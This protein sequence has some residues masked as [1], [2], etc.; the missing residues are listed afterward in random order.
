MINSNFEKLRLRRLSLKLRFLN[1]YQLCIFTFLSFIALSASSQSEVIEV[2]IE[3]LVNVT[4]LEAR[5]V[6]QSKV[7]DPFSPALAARIQDDIRALWSLDVFESIVVEDEKTPGGV[8]LIYNVI[9]KAKVIDIQYTGN[10]KYKQKR[11]NEELGFTKFSRLFIDT[12]LADNYQ[13]KLQTFYTS[14]SFPNTTISWETKETDNENEVILVYHIEEGEKL[15]VKKIVFDGNSVLTDKMLKDRINTKESFWFIFKK[16]YDE[17]IAKE[18]LDIIRFTY[19]TVG[20]LD[21][22]A[23]LEPIEPIKGGLQVRFIIEEGE[24]Y[25]VGSIAIVGNSIYSEDEIRSM[26]R[27]KPG[28]LFSAETALLDRVDIQ[29]LYRGQGFLDTVAPYEPIIDK[30][31]KVV[32][33]LY[34]IQESDR[35]FLGKVDIVGGAVLDDGTFVPAQEGE[36]AT[37]DFVILREIELE[38]GEPLDWTR[39]LESDRNLINLDYFESR[40]FPVPGQLNLYP[41]FIRRKTS[42]PNIENLELRLQEKET[43]VLSFGAGLSTA[44]GPSVFATLTKKNMFGY[45]IRGSI[46]G[47]V[48]ELRNQISLSIFE[49]H[50]LN[51]E[52]STKWDIY[53]LDQD[54]YG[55]RR[56]EEQRYGS[57]LTF[58]RE[59]TKEFDLLFGIRGEITDLQPDLGNQYILDP[60]TVPEVYQLGETTTTSISFG[61]AWDDRD[62]RLDPQN[63]IYNR[64]LIEIAGMTDNEYV[65]WEN[66][67]NYYQPV[68]EKLIL[69][70]SGELNLGYPYGN[71]GFIPIQDRFFEGGSRSIRGF[72]EGSIGEYAIIEYEDNDGNRGGFRTYLGGE[73]SFVGNV[74]L[75]YPISEM[76]QVVTFLDMGSVWQKIE[77]IDPSD[78]RFSTGAGIRVKIPGMNALI[79]V[80]LGFALRKFPEDETEI[81]HFSF[82]QSF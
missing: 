1:I 60:D 12:R 47:E 7:G 72:D 77:N 76:F 58:G 66:V 29:N 11:L 33:I 38:E 18:D 35:K 56:F 65:K 15:P 43:G 74:E 3:G 45:G 22:T 46:T 79:R 5:E 9:E 10:E 78:F 34:Q 50:L 4:E 17:K 69:A 63:G 81:L 24:P 6:I 59:M 62:F 48:G 20:Y 41:G 26:I 21:A 55:G 23:T 73:A 70:L 2:R 31:N 19:A 61:Y 49:P 25:T 13:S 30:K 51:S 44:Y 32:N 16:Q 8:I 42:D 75:R 36:F 71:P 82:G 64:S 14:K 57:G 67:V 54:G 53:Y 52:Y 40:G 27:M 28:D 37:K 39:V 68:F 80:D